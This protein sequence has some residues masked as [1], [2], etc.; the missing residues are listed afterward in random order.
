MTYQTYDAGICVMTKIFHLIGGKWKPIILYLIQQNINR[1]GAL[2]KSM[3]RISKKVLT[4]QL[5]ELEE[6]QLISR[7]VHTATAPQVVVYHLTAKGIS[8]R[9]LIEDMIRWGMEYFKHEYSEELIG[10]FLKKPPVTKTVD[11]R[12]QHVF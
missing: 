1:F 7:H 4:E 2:K 8:L 10:E 6:D 11:V 9:T 12:T 5:R 3:P